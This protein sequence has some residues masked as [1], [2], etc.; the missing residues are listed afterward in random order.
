MSES[1]TFTDKL[2]KERKHDK[3]DS[4]S[5]NHKRNVRYRIRKQE[6]KEAEELI[7]KYDPSRTD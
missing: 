3:N 5:R 7:K 1:N 2:V 4:L 6:E